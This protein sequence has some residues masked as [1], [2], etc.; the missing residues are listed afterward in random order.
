MHN[1]QSHTRHRFITLRRARSSLNH[2]MCSPEIDL[3][4]ITFPPSLLQISV[5][6]RRPKRARKGEAL[7]IHSV[8][9][10]APWIYDEK[11]S[12]VM[13]FLFGTLMFIAGE[14]ENLELQIQGPPSR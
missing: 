14:D 6:I 7:K 4:Y 1:Q 8:G 5:E 2:I 12:M 9:L 10:M 13:Q 3:T 11:F